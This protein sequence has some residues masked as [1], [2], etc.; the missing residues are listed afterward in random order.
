MSR[1]L[2]ALWT[3]FAFAVVSTFGY[4]LTLFCLPVI[5]LD[6]R[7]KLGGQ[8]IRFWGRR[9]VAAVPAWKMRYLEPMPRALPERCVVISNHCSNVDP[10][11][12]AHL[13]WEMKFIAKSTLFKIPSV[14]WGMVIAG[15]ISV[16]RGSGKSIKA[17]MKKASFYLQRGMPVLFFPE[18]TR[19]KTGELLPFKDGAFRLA[20]E[21]GADIL[22]LA[23]AGTRGALKK[24]DWK[25]SKAEG[26]VIAGQPIST[27]GLSL[28]DLKTLKQS[29]RDAVTSLCQQLKERGYD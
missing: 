13:P 26:V 7:R 3:W 1:N 8:M 2:L 15:D 4:I 27:A 14:G 20:I 24:G 5:L 19:S 17:A 28:K 23:V 12:L 18:G 29:S 6:P 16:V 9:M 25:P 22:P 10:F 21:N 11:L